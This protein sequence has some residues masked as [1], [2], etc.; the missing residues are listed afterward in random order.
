[1]YKVHTFIYLFFCLTK[2]NYSGW[3]DVPELSHFYNNVLFFLVLSVPVFLLLSSFIAH[4]L[5]LPLET[6]SREN[7]S[8]PS[9]FCRCVDRL[10]SLRSVYPHMHT[11]T[12]TYIHKPPF[13]LTTTSA[14]KPWSSTRSATVFWALLKS[15]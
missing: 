10:G 1:M 12:L 13:L 15:D 11:Y 9:V 4:G 6:R 5:G 14:L 2:K 8:L 3:R 7:M